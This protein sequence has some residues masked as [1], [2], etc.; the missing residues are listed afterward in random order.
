MADE[1]GGLFACG[2]EDETSAFTTHWTNKSDASSLLTVSTAVPNNGANSGL[3]TCD[4]SHLAYAYKTIADQTEVYARAYVRLGANTAGSGTYSG[5]WCFCLSHGATALVN[6]GFFWDATKT[7][8]H[9]YCSCRVPSATSIYN[10]G[11]GELTHSQWYRLEIY[12]KAHASVG[13]ATFWVDGTQKGSVMNLA[14]T[15]ANH[16]DTVRIGVGAQS[17]D[18]LTNASLF[19]F[20]DVKVDTSAIGAYVEPVSALTGVRITRQIG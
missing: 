1:A 7:S 2:M 14:T 17:C 9:W 3:V 4:G 15:T 6:S 19:Y 12:Y 10:G 8:W 20:D 11:A 18:T 16:C 13:G 5:C